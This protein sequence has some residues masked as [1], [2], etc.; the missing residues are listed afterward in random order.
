AHHGHVEVVA[1]A[2]VEMDRELL[3]ADDLG[4]A[5]RRGDRARGQRGE[6]GGVEAPGVAGLGQE[7]AVLVDDEDALGVGVP[8]Q[9]FAHAQDLAVVLVVQHELGVD[10]RHVRP[11]VG[12]DVGFGGRPTLL[13]Q[14]PARQAASLSD[15][16]PHRRAPS[17]ALV[18]R[19]HISRRWSRERPTVT[20]S[21][22]SRSPP[23]GMP[24]AMRVTRTPVAR[25]GSA[26]RWAVASPSAVGFVARITS[27]T[28]PART[29]SSSSRTRSSSGPMPSIGESAPPSTW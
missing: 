2:L 20:W 18:A 23:S 10:D 6:A 27:R 5:A 28:P 3:L 24:E 21:A 11:Q 1:H 16:S 9:A 25:S 8:G 26:S 7:L 12:V 14:S 15:P 22:Y 4:E 17:R 19:A 13:P 29:R